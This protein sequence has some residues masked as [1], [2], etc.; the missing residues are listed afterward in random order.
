MVFFLSFLQCLT[1]WV[2][3]DGYGKGSTV[4]YAQFRGMLFLLVMVL[5]ILACFQ[6]LLLI[7]HVENSR[8]IPSISCYFLHCLSY[9]SFGFNRLLLGFI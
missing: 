1:W 5:I 9:T 3:G 7:D 6:L 4:E 2:R 8:L